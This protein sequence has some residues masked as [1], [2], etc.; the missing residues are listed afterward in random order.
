VIL[1]APPEIRGFPHTG[2]WDEPGPGAGIR[3]GS[4]NVFR[5]Y[6]LVHQGSKD[7]TVVG[8]SCFVMNKVYIAHDCELSDSV[9]LAASVSLGGHVRVGAGA[10]VGLSSQVHQR[11]VIGPGSMVGM[12]SVVTRDVPPYAK[13]FGTPARFQG[14]NTAGLDRAQIPEVAQ[15]W[16][17]QAYADHTV[18][19][20]PQVFAPPLSDVP[21]VLRSGLQWWSSTSTR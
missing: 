6:S 8:S 5:E 12:G 11:R 13:V 14:L 10:N 15:E 21:E 3:I 19:R 7:A 16:L 2:D 1:G 9:T 18:G 4:L 17:R 20:A